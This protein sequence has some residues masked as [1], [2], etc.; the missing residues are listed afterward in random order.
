MNDY[1]AGQITLCGDYYQYTP[2]GAANFKRLGRWTQTPSRGYIAFFYSK[3][4]GRIGHTGIVTKALHNASDGTW[5]IWTIEGNTSSEKTDRN[6]GEVRLKEYSHVKV[7]GEN[8]FNGFGIPVYGADTCASEN[9]IA[10]AQGEIGYEEKKS[11]AYLYDKT[12]NPGRNNYTKYGEW[13]GLN[14]AQWCAQFVSWCVYQACLASA[15]YPPGWIEQDDGSWTYRKKDGTFAKNEWMLI[16]GRWYVFAG[17]GRMIVGWFDDGTN[18]Y[19]MADDGAMCSGQWVQEGSVWYYLTKS[20]AMAKDAYVSCLP[21]G[22]CYVASDGQW[23]GKYSDTPM[24]G[25]DIAV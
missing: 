20:G 3:S 15:S 17:D 4:L 25:A 1:Q 2:S 23:D 21:M 16:N 7:G 18:W 8:W 22:W 12:A 11:N 13:Y 19:Y 10:I 24:P 6:G 5:D 9:L 14:P